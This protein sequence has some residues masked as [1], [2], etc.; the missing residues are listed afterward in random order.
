MAGVKCQMSDDILVSHM[1]LKTLLLLKLFYFPLRF[2]EKLHL[3]SN[4]EEMRVGFS[5][6]IHYKVVF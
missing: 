5:N 3:Y 2:T 6:Q 1:Y 4:I